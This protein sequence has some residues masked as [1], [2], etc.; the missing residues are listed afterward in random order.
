MRIQR[1]T[2]TDIEISAYE[3]CEAQAAA[4]GQREAFE[5]ERYQRA[6]RAERAARLAVFQERRGSS[7][8]GRLWFGRQG[9]FQERRE[10]S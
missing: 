4:R 10:S 9:V 1:G 6:D 2:E 3:R 7:A 8:S 5:R